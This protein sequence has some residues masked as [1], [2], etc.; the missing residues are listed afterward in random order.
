MHLKERRWGE[1]IY[2]F[3]KYV[4]NNDIPIHRLV[5]TMEPEAMRGVRAGLIALCRADPDFPDFV[6]Y[7]CHS[8]AGLGGKGVGLFSCYDDGN[9]TY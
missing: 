3:K 4:R 8:S 7:H 5:A 2:E 1:D 6:N 9:K